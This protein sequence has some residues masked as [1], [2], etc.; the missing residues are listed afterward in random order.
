MTKSRWSWLVLFAMLVA[1]VW[2]WA[3]SNGNEASTNHRAKFW[4]AFQEHIASLQKIE[5]LSN[6]GKHRVTLIRHPDHGFV[7]QE[8]DWPANMSDVRHLL[9]D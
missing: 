5:V 6:Q 3:Q 4:P 7:V 9:H 1:G 2:W 8:R